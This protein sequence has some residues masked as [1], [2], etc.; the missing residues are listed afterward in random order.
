M[1]M[2]KITSDGQIISRRDVLSGSLPIVAGAAVLTTTGPTLATAAPV[3]TAGVVDIEKLGLSP[4]KS[5][6][7]TDLLQK[8]IDLAAKNGLHLQLPGGSFMCGQLTLRS[9]LS[10]SGVPNATRLRFTGGEAFLTGKK[11]TG[12]SISHLTIDG[13]SRA[14]IGDDRAALLDISDVTGLSI[15]G[16][17]IKDSLLG[18]I[19]VNRCSGRV[20]SSDISLCG[21]SGVFALDSKGL[22][23]SDCHVSDC[24]NNGILVWRS[25]KGYDGTLVTNNRISRIKSQAGG[26][27]QN[28]NGINIYRAGSVV[29]SG[30]MISDCVFSAVRNNGGDNV[31]IL[32]NSCSGLGEVALYSEFN[33]EGAVINNNLVDDAHV[34]ISITNFNDGGRLATATGNLIRNI[35][36]RGKKEGIGI[37]VEADTLVTG[38]VIEAVQ[39]IGIS[40]GWGK[41]M[42][43]VTAN[44]NLI[45][46]TQI[47]IGV[48]THPKAGYALISTNMIIDAKKG[49]IRAMDQNKP[50]G[51]DLTKNS[52]EPFLNLAIYGNVSL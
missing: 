6:D 52:A 27:G 12:L 24:S 51:K 42:R 34:G 3:Q 43:Q 37:A 48:S 18:G 5:K 19:A 47:G 45:R 4:H 23:I 38:N 39:G 22:E 46:Q 49:G 44:N 41:Y 8:A 9:G 11:L 30:N 17:T 14:L 20:Q 25:K 13:R 29:V 7:Q 10:I 28:G 16:C 32:N 1:S 2:K 36:K 31:Q 33:F 50:L 40:I 35:K 21:T 26:S 15:F